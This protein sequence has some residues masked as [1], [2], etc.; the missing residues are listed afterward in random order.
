MRL[1]SLTDAAAPVEKF[2]FMLYTRSMRM[3]NDA[4]ESYAVD[5]CLPGEIAL[6]LHF[7]PFHPH[8]PFVSPDS[9]HC[10]ARPPPPLPARPPRTPSDPIVS[11]K[12]HEM[13]TDAGVSNGVRDARDVMTENSANTFD[14]LLW[15]RTYAYASKV[16]GNGDR[17]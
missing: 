14:R 16:D 1:S 4:R 6:A 11:I 7:R 17:L 15:G 3:K 9:F 2:L 13:T 12:T 10:G 8:L 5:D